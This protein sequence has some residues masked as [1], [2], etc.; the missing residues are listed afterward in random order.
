M[1]VSTIFKSTVS[2]HSRRVL[3]PAASCLATRCLLQLAQEVTDLLRGSHLLRTAFYMDD[4]ITG[5]DCSEEGTKMQAELSE[6]LQRSGM[7]L[8]KRCSSNNATLTNVSLE[9]RETT[10][11]FTIANDATIETLG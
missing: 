4:L 6:A 11:N 5:V 8:R 9:H 1:K 2:Q 7:E 10:N 3:V